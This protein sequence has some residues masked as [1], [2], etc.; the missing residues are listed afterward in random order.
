[1]RQIHLLQ[2]GLDD[3][4]MPVVDQPLQAVETQSK[5]EEDIESLLMQLGVNYQWLS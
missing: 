5:L 3:Y 2:M 1:M 4:C